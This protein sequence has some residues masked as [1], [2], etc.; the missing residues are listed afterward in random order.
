MKEYSLLTFGGGI[1][2]KLDLSE[3]LDEIDGVPCPCPR[4][5]SPLARLAE[6]PNP[7]FRQLSPALPPL[8]LVAT[9]LTERTLPLL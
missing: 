7:L 1:P 6:L 3:F 8:T 4:F 9:V 2:A 5:L